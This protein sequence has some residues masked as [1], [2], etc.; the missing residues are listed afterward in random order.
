MKEIATLIWLFGGLL[1]F[2][3]LIMLYANYRMG[4]PTKKSWIIAILGTVLIFTIVI[5]EDIGKI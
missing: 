4:R 2:V 3:G 1:S 5:L